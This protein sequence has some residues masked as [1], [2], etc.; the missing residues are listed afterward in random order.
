MNTP[1]RVLAILLLLALVSLPAMAGQT[2]ITSVDTARIQSLLGDLGFTGSEVDEDGDVIVM[3]QG[4]P[5]VLIIGSG[6]ARQIQA[7]VAFV[8]MGITMEQVNQWNATRLLSK[9]YIDGDGDTIFE[10]DL[11][12]D[13]GVTVDR[14][15]DWLQTFNM[16]MDMFVREVIQGKGFDSPRRPTRSRDLQVGLHSVPA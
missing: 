1:L 14:V 3:M 9:A 11:D 12:M 10:S 2:V 15:K 13:G 7:V 8:D 6:N 16:M 4:R 5:V